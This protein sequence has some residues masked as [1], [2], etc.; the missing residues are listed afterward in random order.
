MKKSLILTT[1]LGFIGGYL[2]SQLITARRF[3]KEDIHDIFERL[4]EKGLQQISLSTY[5]S[6]NK[7]ID[8]EFKA[9]LNNQRVEGTVLWKS[10]QQV[11]EIQIKEKQI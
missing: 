4:S 2:L 3:S 5:R 8:V 7:T 10:G 11:P 9:L 6:N 1:T